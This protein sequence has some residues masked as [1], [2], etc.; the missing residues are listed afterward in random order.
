MTKKRTVFTSTRERA[1]AMNIKVP[2]ETKSRIDGLKEALRQVDDSLA[3]NVSKVCGDALLAAVK[4]GENELARMRPVATA[5]AS[6]S[7]EAGR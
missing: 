5:K 6:P 3:F 4:K 2:V 1:V 7:S